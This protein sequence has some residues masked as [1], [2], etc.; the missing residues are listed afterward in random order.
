MATK[1]VTNC[2]IY[3]TGVVLKTKRNL[4]YVECG[5]GHCIP[6]TTILYQTQSHFHFMT[7]AIIWYGFQKP[8]F[9][10]DSDSLVKT[11][12]AETLLPR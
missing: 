6:Q 9:R 5:M 2:S 7:T 11:Q 4:I 8:Q 10:Q 12:A 1:G 3:R